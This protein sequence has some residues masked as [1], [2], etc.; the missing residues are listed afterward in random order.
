VND[1]KLFDIKVLPPNIKLKNVDFM[2]K[3]SHTICFGLSHI[4]S[5]GERAI[6]Q[7]LETRVDFNDFYSFIFDCRL[8]KSTVI[9]LI[10]SG[11]LDDFNVSRDK[12]LREY[13][14][15]K[16]LTAKQQENLKKLFTKNI[17]CSVISIVRDLGDESKAESWKEHDIRSPNI[18]ARKKLRDLV[19]E[20]EGIELLSSHQILTLEEEYLGISTTPRQIPRRGSHTCLDIKRNCLTNMTVRVIAYIAE[21]NCF[22][23]KKDDLDMAFISIEDDTYMLDGVVVFHDLYEEVSSILGIGCLVEV[24]GK[25]DNAGSLICS[26]IRAI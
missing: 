23:T 11:A 14:L 26:G 24:I 2:I 13:K 17:G 21:V 25:M 6:S 19:A 5:L 20:Y 10:C 16:K 7:V 8:N 18:N 22:K 12:M 3:D 15:L 9:S 1:A 4:K